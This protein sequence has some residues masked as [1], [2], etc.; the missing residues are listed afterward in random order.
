METSTWF[1]ALGREER[2]LVLSLLHDLRHH[3]DENPIQFPAGVHELL[4]GLLLNL[5][6]EHEQTK[7]AEDN[8]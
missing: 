6:E 2:K 8:P 4:R 5:E 3:I 7:C 1:K